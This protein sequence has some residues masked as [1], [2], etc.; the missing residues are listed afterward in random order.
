M[1]SIALVFAFVGAMCLACLFLVVLV[2]VGLGAMK[3]VR[4][5]SNLA[6]MKEVDPSDGIDD[7]ELAILKNALGKQRETEQTNAAKEAISKAIA[8]L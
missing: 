2:F 7:R 5:R 1:N 8:Q 4:E 3:I 6:K